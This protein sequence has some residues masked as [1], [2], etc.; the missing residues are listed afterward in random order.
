MPGVFMEELLKLIQEEGFPLP[1]RIL[2]I[3]HEEI[4]KKGV[5]QELLDKLRLD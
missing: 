1:D 3:D 4:K 2:E 5:P